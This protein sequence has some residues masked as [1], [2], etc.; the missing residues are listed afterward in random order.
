MMGCHRA[1]WDVTGHEGTGGMGRDVSPALCLQDM[2]WLAG[3]DVGSPGQ[4]RCLTGIAPSREFNWG[5]AGA[6]GLA[7]KFH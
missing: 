2:P 1:W 3:W 6:Q 7:E 5:W 4:C